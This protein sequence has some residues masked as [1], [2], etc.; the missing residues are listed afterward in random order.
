[1]GKEIP[2]EFYKK[3]ARRYRQIQRTG[4]GPMNPADY[5]ENEGELDENGED[6][7]MQR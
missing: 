6:N 7:A 1:M 5:Y 3:V 2:K 4:I